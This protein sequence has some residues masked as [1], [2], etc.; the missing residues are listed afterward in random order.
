M[1]DNTHNDN[2]H[3][4]HA[5]MQCINDDIEHARAIFKRMHIHDYDD[6]DASCELCNPAQ[7]RTRIVR[8]TKRV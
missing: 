3:E 7:I 4:L 1:N 6:Y 2:E 5:I 8:V